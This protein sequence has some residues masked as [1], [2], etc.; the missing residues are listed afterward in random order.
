MGV[1]HMLKFYILAVVVLVFGFFVMYNRKFLNILGF[2]LDKTE[3]F[4]YRYIGRYIKKLNTNLERTATI[5]KGSLT[6]RITMY[7]KDIIVNLDM[8]K[9]N[10][11]VAGLLSFITSLALALSILLTIFTRDLVLFPFLFLALFYTITI[12]FRFFALMRF[13]KTEAHIMDTED[14]IA[15]DV[16]GGVYNAILRYHKSFHPSMQPFFN[17]FIDNIQN[18][19]YSFRDAMVILNDRLGPTFTEFAQKAIQYEERGDDKMEDIF[20]SIVEINRYRR[21]I[22]FENNIKFNQL[23]M[24]FLVSIC[25]IAGYAIFSVFTDGFLAHFFLNTTLGKI[26]IVVD[27][28]IIAFV[29]AFIASIKAKLL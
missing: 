28:L 10:V 9:D 21:T 18:K 17:E 22:R 2:T 15:M 14:L 6:H 26:L 29:L 1:R 11:T 24:Q 12:V 20:A 27:L 3:G 5:K 13:E 7:Y 4:F 19:G 23:R 8:V 16:K 25:I